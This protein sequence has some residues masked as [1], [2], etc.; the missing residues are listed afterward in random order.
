MPYNRST[1]NTDYIPTKP[2]GQNSTE[3][4]PPKPI[5]TL[6]YEPLNIDNFTDRISNLPSNIDSY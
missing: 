6:L 1:N 4:P 3:K 2:A 5:L